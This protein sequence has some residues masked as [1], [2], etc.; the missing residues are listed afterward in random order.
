MMDNHQIGDAPADAAIQREMMAV[1]R[2]IDMW[3]KDRT[4][5]VPWGFIIMMFPLD[6][7]EGRC[8]YMSN[9]KRED[10]V[11]LLKEQIRRFEGGAEIPPGHA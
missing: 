8:N 10:I 1:A 3:L 2:T 4:A 11:V 9:A 5:P 6:D 7:H